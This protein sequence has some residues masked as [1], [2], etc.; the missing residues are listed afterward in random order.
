MEKICFGRTIVSDGYHRRVLYKI[1]FFT[2]HSF[3]IHLSSLIH[4]FLFFLF[5]TSFF[6]VGID[7]LNV[8]SKLQKVAFVKLDFLTENVAKT[9]SRIDEILKFNEKKHGSSYTSKISEDCILFYFKGK[10][11]PYGYTNNCG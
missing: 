8:S 6:N 3:L 5:K 4:S 9:D 2:Y 7:Y 1:F 11:Y 10:P